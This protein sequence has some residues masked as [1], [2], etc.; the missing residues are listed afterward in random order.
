[1]NLTREQAIAEHRKM[2]NW[3]ADMTEKLKHRV[4]KGEYFSEMEINNVP[5]LGC[6]CCEFEHHN[7]NCCNEYCIIDWGYGKSC[8]DSYYRKWSSTNDWQE[9]ARLSRI[10]AN[11]PERE[12]SD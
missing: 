11:L 2:W 12:V 10:I 4:E 3:I 6:Y 9:A 7:P 8:T 1:M 5:H